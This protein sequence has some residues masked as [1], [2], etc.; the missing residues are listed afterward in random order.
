MIAWDTRTGDA[1]KRDWLYRL[2]AGCTVVGLV[3]QPR[4]LGAALNAL[5]VDV[6]AAMVRS[7]MLRQ[8]SGGV[9]RYN[10]TNTSAVGWVR[11]LDQLGAS[12]EQNNH[13][14]HSGAA[15]GTRVPFAEWLA[16]V[17]A[18]CERARASGESDVLEL[19]SGLLYFASANGLP[20]DTGVAHSVDNALLALSAAHDASEMFNLQS[21]RALLAQKASTDALCRF[22]AAD[23]RVVGAL[24]R[25]HAGPH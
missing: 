1:N 11:L 13:L 6:A 25:A 21:G 20:D 9:E 10:V 18:V 23:E 16:E 7:V 14:R 19:A 22:I 3:P 8:A 4:P 17:V 12:L 24:G 15:F 5:P 2:L